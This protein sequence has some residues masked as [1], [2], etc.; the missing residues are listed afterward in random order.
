MSLEDELSNA[1]TMFRDKLDSRPTSKSENVAQNGIQERGA[2]FSSQLPIAAT[3]E[4][5]SGNANNDTQQ[6]PPKLPPAVTCLGFSTNNL[7]I[8]VAGI[9]I[10]PI[11]FPDAT[12]PNGVFSLPF[13]QQFPASGGAL[14]FCRYQVIAG[15]TGYVFDI[16]SDGS[17]DAF[18]L[19]GGFS[20]ADYFE[21]SG[22][23]GSTIN[24]DFTGPCGGNPDTP[25]F[26][27]TVDASF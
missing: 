25:G 6:N 1:I 10:C 14:A 2:S 15:S 12:D 23:F 27:G 11:D 9:T 4:P 5:R 8:T 22:A 3:N 7:T 18:V 16:F 20:G 13:F 24:N 21:G 19:L 26:G 17:S